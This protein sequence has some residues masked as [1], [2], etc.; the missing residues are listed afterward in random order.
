[1]PEAAAVEGMGRDAAAHRST[2]VRTAG[3][4]SGCDQD[5]RAPV[6]SAK[7]DDLVLDFSKLAAQAAA[8]SAALAAA[9][10]AAG[11]GRQQVIQVHYTGAVDAVP[12]PAHPSPSPCQVRDQLAQLLPP[13]AGRVQDQAAVAALA[14]ADAAEAGR[15][16]QQG[17]DGVA[18]AD[19]D[20]SRKGGRGQRMKQW[21]AALS[22]RMKGLRGGSKGKGAAA[23]G[24]GSFRS[25]SSVNDHMLGFTGGSQ[26]AMQC[27]AHVSWLALKPHTSQYWSGSLS[28]PRVPR[29]S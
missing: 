4:G 28:R 21:R 13:A 26:A 2:D 12:V 7:G 1:M 29:R 8:P 23:G 27:P 25:N 22:G 5:S 15:A 24:A 11:A 16:G 10:L 17:M 9:A 6:G 3:F 19:K 20:V 18:A 14:A